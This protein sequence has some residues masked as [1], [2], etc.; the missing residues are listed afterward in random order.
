MAATAASI[1]FTGGDSFSQKWKF[2]DGRCNIWGTG[3]RIRS[4][5]T[6]AAMKSLHPLA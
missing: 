1:N 3:I 2:F 6:V 4:A 5:A